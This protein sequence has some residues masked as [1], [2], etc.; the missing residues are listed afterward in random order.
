MNL[1]IMYVM[2]SSDTVSNRYIGCDQGF[3]VSRD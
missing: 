1:S 3:V 2:G